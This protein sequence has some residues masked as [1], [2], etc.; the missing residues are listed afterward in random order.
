MLTKAIYITITAIGSSEPIRTSSSQVEGKIKELINP[1]YPLRNILLITKL[2][3]SSL[4]LINGLV[5]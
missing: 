4:I 2:K 1:F 3:I 5:S